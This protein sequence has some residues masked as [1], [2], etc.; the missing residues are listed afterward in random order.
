[1]FDAK[2]FIENEFGSPVNLLNA[3]QGAGYDAPVE[4]SIYRWIGRNSIPTA[5]LTAALLIREIEEGRPLSLRPYVG[6]GDSP[7]SVFD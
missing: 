3:L 6:G 5:W 7:K 1:M 2:K 4:N